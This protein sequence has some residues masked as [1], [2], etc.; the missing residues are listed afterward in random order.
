MNSQTAEMMKYLE[1][2]RG[3]GADHMALPSTE[4]EK[5]DRE[6]EYFETVCDQVY[7]ILENS[8]Y[9]LKRQQTLL[10]Q[11]LEATA[12]VSQAQIPTSSVQ[13]DETIVA[14]TVS[15]PAISI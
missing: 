11:E 1:N 6:W 8:T 7:F 12:T 14:P 13:L 9:K 10:N 4:Q 3:L 15:I 5:L 2:M